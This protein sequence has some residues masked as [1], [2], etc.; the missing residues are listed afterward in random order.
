MG[1]P[2]RASGAVPDTLPG[3]AVAADQWKTAD[4]VR[5]VLTDDER[6][7]EASEESFP[8]SDAPAWTHGRAPELRRSHPKA[9]RRRTPR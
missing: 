5:D 6:I 7:D 3:N 8:A 4:R 1:D 9:D 2:T